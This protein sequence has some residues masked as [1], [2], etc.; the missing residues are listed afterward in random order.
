MVIQNDYFHNHNQS[1]SSSCPSIRIDLVS[2]IE[3]IHFS[4]DLQ[5]LF[6]YIKL[7]LLH[8]IIFVTQ[9]AC[10][11][12]MLIYYD[13]KHLLLMQKQLSRHYSLQYKLTTSTEPLK[14]DL[15]YKHKKESNNY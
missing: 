3:I 9:F 12:C 7:Y 10:T 13:S 5:G 8:Q 11:A 14:R 2:L 4:S 1:K 6:C 15:V